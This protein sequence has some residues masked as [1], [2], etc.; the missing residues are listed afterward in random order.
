MVTILSPLGVLVQK[1]G[2]VLSYTVWLL[3]SVSSVVEFTIWWVLKSKHFAQESTCWEGIL[4]PTTLNYLWYS[5]VG[6]VKVD[7]FDFPCEIFKIVCE[8]DIGVIACNFYVFGIFSF[9]SDFF[10]SNSFIF[11]WKVEKNIWV[12]FPLNLCHWTQIWH[13]K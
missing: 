2:I 12:F 9:F 5:V 1:T 13:Q 3:N 7:Y 10:R 11:E 4:I 6:V 8:I